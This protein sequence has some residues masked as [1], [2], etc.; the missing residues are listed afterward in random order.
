MVP[1]V[2]YT[3][4]FSPIMVEEG[5]QTIT[6]INLHFINKDLVQYTPAEECWVLDVY[7]VEAA[8]LNADPSTKMY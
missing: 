8:F 7:D 1:T 5:V 3:K 4:S 2:D 6:G